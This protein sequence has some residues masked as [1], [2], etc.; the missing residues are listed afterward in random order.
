MCLFRVH[1]FNTLYLLHVG[2]PVDLCICGTTT[3]CRGQQR[4]PGVYVQGTRST[5]SN[6]STVSNTSRQ[7]D[8]AVAARLLFGSVIACSQAEYECEL[9]ELAMLRV[10]T[11][12]V[13]KQ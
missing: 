9:P 12:M 6:D 13:Y 5:M 1:L 4:F 11:M 3:R 2:R 8:T 7:T 10:F